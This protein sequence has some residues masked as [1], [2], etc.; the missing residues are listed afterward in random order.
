MTC[1]CCPGNNK[2]EEKINKFPRLEIYP[3]TENRKSKQQDSGRA[4]PPIT[5][6]QSPKRPTPP[7]L[8]SVGY[9]NPKGIVSV[10]RSPHRC[11]REF[12]RVLEEETHR[13]NPETRFL[14]TPSADE[15]T[16][17]RK[18]LQHQKNW[19]TWSLFREPPDPTGNPGPLFGYLL[20]V[21]FCMAYPFW[22]AEQAVSGLAESSLVMNPYGSTATFS[23]GVLG[24]SWRLHT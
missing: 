10:S 11:S 1:I 14:V 15:R 23:E 9:S 24:P 3:G 18:N 13:A 7:L 5:G 12:S 21:G 19:S 17:E 22:G 4:P 2:Y 8:E 16:E 6:F 20:V